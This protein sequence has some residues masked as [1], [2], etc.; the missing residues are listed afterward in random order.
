MSVKAGDFNYCL[1]SRLE[2]E[3][4]RNSDLDEEL[5]CTYFTARTQGHPSDVF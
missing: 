5:L 2:L 1:S 3:K 4:G